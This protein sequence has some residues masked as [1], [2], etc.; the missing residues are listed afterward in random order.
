MLNQNRFI[1]MFQKE[2]EPHISMDIKLND[3]LESKF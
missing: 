3:W 2:Y 1:C